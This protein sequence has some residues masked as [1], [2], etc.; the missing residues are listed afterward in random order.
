MYNEMSCGAE[1]QLETKPNGLLHF[2]NCI[3]ILDRDNL[4]TFVMNEAHKTH[5]SVHPDADKMYK[6]LRTQYWWPGIKKDIAPYV[7]KCLTCLKV[8]AEHQRPSGL[9]EQPEIPVWKWECIS[10]DFISKLP[11]TSRGHDSIWVIIDRLTK[12][13]YFLPM[14]EG[15]RV[16]KLA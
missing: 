15:Y 10:M 2:L 3:W 9:L 4:H 6:D 13:A 1:L 7:S 12:S 14:R 8:K 5:Y 16:E 11:H